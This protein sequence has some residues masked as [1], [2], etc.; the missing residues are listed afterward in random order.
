MDEII[1]TI[2]KIIWLIIIIFW[3]ISGFRAK[4]VERQESKISRF[5]QYWF[6][7]IL[8]VLLLGPGEWFGRTIFREALIKSSNTLGIIGLFFCIAGAIIACWSRFLLGKNWSLSIQKKENHKLIQTGLYKSIRHPIYTGLLLLFTG[9]AI[10]ISEYRVIPA[11]L[12]IFFSF[13][14]KLKKEES[15][16][17]KTSGDEYHKYMDKTK[18]LIPYI[19]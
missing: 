14:F 10:I 4:K 2:L 11:L 3:T 8:A 16:M 19:L 7:L 5:F 1:K 15:L 9:N 13:W 17:I 18:A 12:I 6:P